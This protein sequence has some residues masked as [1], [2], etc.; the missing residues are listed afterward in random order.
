MKVSVKDF[1]AMCDG[2][3][4]DTAAFNA[5]LNSSY[6]V[7]VTVPAGTTSIVRNIAPPSVSSL[8]SEGNWFNTILKAPDAGS[9]VILLNYG[10]VDVVVKDFWLTRSIPA[11]GGDG[12]HAPAYN[13]NIRLENLYVDNQWIGMHLGVTGNSYVKTAMI[14]DCYVHGILLLPDTTASGGIGGAQWQLEDILSTKNE[15]CGVKVDAVYTNTGS[16]TLGNWNKIRTFGNHLQGICLQG[17]PGNGIYDLVC[18]GGFLGAEGSH[19]IYVDSYG[20][21]NIFTAFSIEQCGTQ[22]NGRGLAHAP[23]MAGSAVYVSGNSS[24]TV[25]GN[26]IINTPANFGIINFGHRTVMSGSSISYCGQSGV[27]A[28]GIYAAGGSL[29]VS[30]TTS[31]H[32]Q[33]GMYMDVDTVCA[34]GL[35][36]SDN[37]I[38]SVGGT[39]AVRSKLSGIYV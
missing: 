35:D 25:F 4:D 14:S 21:N 29:T 7:T 17:K 33:F 9:H 11:V 22:P 38:A 16:V 5:A 23:P 30:G 26:M 37:S 2:V 32:Q 6:G 24:E 39:P 27:G 1:G 15:G 31:T 36:L 28:T 10:V 34:S 3:T 13:E 8:I 12:V 19:E 20:S 18:T